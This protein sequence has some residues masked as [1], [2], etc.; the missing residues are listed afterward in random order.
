MIVQL[1]ARTSKCWIIVIPLTINYKSFKELISNRLLRDGRLKTRIIFVCALFCLILVQTLSS[2]AFGQSTKPVW[3][4][5]DVW[6]YKTS[7]MDIYTQN[8]TMDFSD[9]STINVNGTDYD[10]Y[11]LN[12]TSVIFLSGNEY[13]YT[14][15][16]YHLISNLAILRKE[17]TLSRESNNQSLVITYEPPKEDYEFP[18]SVGASWTS[19]FTESECTTFNDVVMGYNNYT[20]TVTY[21][22]LEEGNIEVEAG[23][24]ECYLIEGDDGGGEITRIY[25]SPEVKNAVKIRTESHGMM[26]QDSEL[27]YYDVTAPPENGEDE[28]NE[29]G[30]ED[31]DEF[32]MP[33]LLMLFIIPIIIAVV[34]IA[35]MATRKK[36][37]PEEVL[38]SAQA[39]ETPSGSQQTP[40]QPAASP[41]P[42][43]IPPPPPPQRP[44]PTCGKPL[45]YIQ[46]YKSHYCYN[47]SKYA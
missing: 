15:H 22:V 1:L 37:K 9:I 14:G 39:Y 2:T 35:A 30:G 11:V 28:Y 43:A 3:V 25:Y 41:T 36:K 26:T 20:K 13:N 4:E 29:T 5:G 47:C 19:T 10:V 21:T 40:P 46:Q 31:S 18:L 7:Q 33:W 16:D 45:S 24:F 8:D 27:T 12:T 34:I 42:I 23:E 44:C 6:E 38:M 32:T 17:M